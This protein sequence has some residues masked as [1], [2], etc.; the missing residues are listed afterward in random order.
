MALSLLLLTIVVSTPAPASALAADCSAISGY[1]DLVGLDLSGCYL[2][3]AELPQARLAGANLSDASLA[4][5]NLSYADLSGADLTRVALGFSDLSYADLTGA[6]LVGASLRAV[7]LSGVSLVNANLSGAFLREAGLYGANLSG[8]IVDDLAFVGVFLNESTICPDGEFAVRDTRDDAWSSLAFT[9]VRDETAPLLVVP[10]NVVHSA[11]GSSVTEVSFG[12]V[13]A[14][15]DYGVAA[16]SCWNAASGE[17]VGVAGGPYPLGT[18]V[19]T[20]EAQ[21]P[22]GN[23]TT[24]SFSVSVVYEW[25]RLGRAWGNLA[26]WRGARSVPITLQLTGASAKVSDARIRLYVA[27]VVNGVAGPE[28]VASTRSKSASGQFEYRKGFR[29]D[30]GWY[31]FDW[32]VSALGRGTYQ[33]RIDLGDGTTNTLV[34]YRR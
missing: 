6:T 13:T 29:G 14:D 4:F 20:C 16:L 28:V 19:V 23:V 21:D 31:Q 5:A 27:P 11:T 34:V 24:D 8:A 7:T 15:D 12:P 1:P 3:Y 30:L 18:T 2:D 33:L 22:S 9:C 17:Q 32:N 25:Q 26:T 10:E